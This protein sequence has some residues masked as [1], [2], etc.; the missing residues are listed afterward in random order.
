MPIITGLER[1]LSLSASGKFGC[2]NQYGTSQFG[3]SHYGE[4]DIYFGTALFGACHFGDTDFGHGFLF[5]GIYRTGKL[6]GQRKEFRQKYYFPYNPRSPSQVK[7]RNKFAEAVK[8]WQDL[9]NEEKMFYN[10]LKG[11]R[12][13]S[14]Y[15]Y[16]ISL[17]LK[18]K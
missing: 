5:S 10:K 7:N 1:L 4:E 16:F 2:Y 13:M 3:M 8:A 17:Y 14:G 6:N 18:Y 9:T 12:K 11:Y 15:N